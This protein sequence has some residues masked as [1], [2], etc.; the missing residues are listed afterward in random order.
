MKV[1][2]TGVGGFVGTALARR[3]AADGE[4]VL[5]TFVGGRPA[6]AGVELEAANILEPSV[7]GPL[8]AD[9]GPEVI[10]HLAGFSH[11]GESWKRLD[12]YFRVNVLGVENVLAA[13]A[14]ARVLLASS[15]EVYGRVPESEQPIVE[16][17][18]VAP[19]NPY[20][21]TKAA[22]ER[23]TL[24]AG[25]SVVRMFN[26]VGPG[27]AEG[28]ALPSFAAQ[29][30]TGGG[31]QVALRVGNLDARRD[32]LHVDDAVGGYA[33]LIRRAEPRG[34]YNL[35][36]GEAFSIRRA[37]DLL[38]EIAGVEA[39]IEVDPERLRPID[40]ELT[41]GDAGRLRALGW[42][43]ERGLRRAL[44][45]LWASVSAASRQTAT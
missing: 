40:V 7:L 9:F 37:L 44:E 39:E 5:G 13:A 19:R 27:Q 26:I 28:F 17:R 16:D 8:V 43:P 22:A 38:I 20:A 33:T 23:L 1:L 31:G 25:G 18:Q 21:M 35:A 42:R 15:A 6:V 36:S 14:G 29:L 30:A 10:V 45:D 4:K 24:A 41:R 2:V 32:F 12:D 11:V 34:V 3:L